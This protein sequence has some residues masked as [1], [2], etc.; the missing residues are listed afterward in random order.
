M[1]SGGK[2]GGE[3]QEFEIDIYILLYFKQTANKDLLH[4]TGNSAQYSF[5]SEMGKKFD[6]EQIYVFAVI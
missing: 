1:V 6:K 5:I 3:G 2:D 4:S